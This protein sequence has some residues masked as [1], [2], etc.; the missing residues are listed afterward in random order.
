MQTA[1]VMR[2]TGRQRH[3]IQETQLSLSVIGLLLSEDDGNPLIHFPGAE[4]GP[5]VVDSFSEGQ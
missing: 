5:Q 3:I 2:H 1:L 4:I